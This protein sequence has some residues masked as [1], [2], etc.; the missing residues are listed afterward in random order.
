MATCIYI[1]VSRVEYDYKENKWLLGLIM[2]QVGPVNM[3]D[4]MIGMVWW[5]SR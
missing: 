1:C 3:F 5:G 2:C 4:R